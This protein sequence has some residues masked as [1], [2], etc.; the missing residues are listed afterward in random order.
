[1]SKCELYT[2]NEKLKHIPSYSCSCSCFTFNVCQVRKNV[3]ETF[4]IWLRPNTASSKVNEDQWTELDH[5]W[6]I[7]PLDTH[8]GQ[9]QSLSACK[10]NNV[11]YKKQKQKTTFFWILTCPSC[12]ACVTFW[13]W[14]PPQ[15]LEPSWWWPH[16]APFHKAQDHIQ[17]SVVSPS[18]PG[19][20]NERWKDGT[21]QNRYYG[22]WIKHTNILHMLF[23]IMLFYVF[24]WAGIYVRYKLPWQNRGHF[25]QLSHNATF[26]CTYWQSSFSYPRDDVWLRAG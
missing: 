17:M 18:T 23:L 14:S 2:K 19:G 13:Q 11:Y 10:T 25:L 20:G 26:H 1:M 8:S 9:T 22:Q 4:W 24:M 6:S 21:G 7:E 12:R 5:S 16:P 15:I 3:R